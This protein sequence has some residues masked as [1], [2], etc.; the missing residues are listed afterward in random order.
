MKSLVVA[1]LVD[2]RLKVRGVVRV[3]VC[4]G[5]LWLWQSLLPL[6][7]WYEDSRWLASLL[8]SW[9]LIGHCSAPLLIVLMRPEFAPYVWLANRRRLGRWLVDRLK[10][11]TGF[12]FES[13][14]PL[15]VNGF[16]AN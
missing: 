15:C 9:P 7:L 10:F 6:L 4:V 8:Y 12:A 1:R 16:S 2:D 11:L 13:L 3:D 5:E 14:L